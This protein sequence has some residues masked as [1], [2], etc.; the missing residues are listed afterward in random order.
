MSLRCSRRWPPRNEPGF[1]IKW[2]GGQHASVAPAVKGG[3]NAPPK[4]ALRALDGAE[5]ARREGQAFHHWR[6]G[7]C[8]HGET[9]RVGL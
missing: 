6:G 4:A 8:A 9:E 7:P 5:P 1:A 2:N 3:A